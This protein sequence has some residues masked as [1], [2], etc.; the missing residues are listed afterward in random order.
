MMSTDK[1]GRPFLKILADRF[2]TGVRHPK[3]FEKLPALEVIAHPAER[4]VILIDDVATSGWHME[5]A[6]LRLRAKGFVAISVVWLRG[7]VDRL[8]RATR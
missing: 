7:T 2:V 1:L 4:T 8:Y 3:K 5:E 6:L